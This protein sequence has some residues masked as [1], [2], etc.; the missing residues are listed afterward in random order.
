MDAILHKI[1]TKGQSVEST[2]SSVS[3]ALRPYQSR[4][5]QEQENL[6]RNAHTRHQTVQVVEQTPEVLFED[7]RFGIT[8][9]R[10]DYADKRVILVIE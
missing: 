1:P 8:L 10:L 6:V 3:T 2:I 5:S 9:S 4:L 7:A